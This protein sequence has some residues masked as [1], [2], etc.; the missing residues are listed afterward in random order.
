MAKR[1]GILFF[2]WGDQHVAEMKQ[3]L[4]ESQLPDYPI[5]LIT[6]ENTPVDWDNERLS[7]IRG[8]FSLRGKLRKVLLVDYLP[9]DID[10][11]LFLDVDTRSSY[12][13]SG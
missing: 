1:R 12:A 9:E 11:F 3:C 6:D 13:I 2:A 7:V 10:S 5:F 8:S 4:Q